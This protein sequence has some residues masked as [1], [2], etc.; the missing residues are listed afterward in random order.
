VHSVGTDPVLSMIATRLGSIASAP[1]SARLASARLD[2]ELSA[3]SAASGATSVLS[4]EVQQWSVRWSEIQV[5]L[6]EC[7]QALQAIGTNPSFPWNCY[8]TPLARLPLRAFCPSAVGEAY[9][10]WIL[11]PRLPGDLAF[12]SCSCEAADHPR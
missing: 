4:A 5:R 11:W 3:A 6:V 7:S 2:S 10:P 9:W 12:D 1:G 8:T